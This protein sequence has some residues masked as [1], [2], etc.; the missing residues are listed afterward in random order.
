[1]KNRLFGSLSFLL[2]AASASL[3]AT[4]PRAQCEHL[5]LTDYDAP[6]YQGGNNRPDY[7]EALDM[8][9]DRL[10]IGIP[11]QNVQGKVELYE[12][13]GLNWR[14]TGVV[15]PPP[16]VFSGS[17]GSDVALSGDRLLVADRFDQAAYVY[18]YT[19]G[20]W[21]Y[22]QELPSAFAITQFTNYARSVA[23]DGDRA[24]V[25]DPRLAGQNGLVFVFECDGDGVWGETG[26]LGN[27]DPT[28]FAVDFGVGLALDGDLA[29]VA[30]PR[31]SV[32]ASQ[33]G[34]VY[35]YRSIGVGW[36]APVRLDPASVATVG[37]YGSSVAVSGGRVLVG[38]ELSGALVTLGGAVHVWEDQAGWSEVDVFT[39]ADTFGGSHFGRSV[40][41]AGDL[42]LVGMPSRDAGGGAI[43]AGGAYVF[44]ESGGGWSQVGGA[45]VPADRGLGD[46]IGT[47]VATNGELVALAAPGDD[48]E[49]PDFGAVSTWSLSGSVCP[50]LQSFPKRLFLA[51]GGVFTMLLRPGVAFANR[52]YILVGD[53]TGPNPGFFHQGFFVPLNQDDWFNIVLENP[54]VGLF[55]GTQGT[56]DGAGRATA[57]FTLPPGLPPALAGIRFHW[58]YVLFDGGG[59][60]LHASTPVQ[61][62]LDV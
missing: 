55:S 1:M 25:S 10:A 5:K 58:A 39:A 50:T 36:E 42:A 43:G 61:L 49:G 41:L 3:L 22:A 23:L 56:L 30:A 11:G 16:G 18:E 13:D 19:G 40:A 24:L 2:A 60:A 46:Q 33:G 45:L 34:A 57:T 47:R 17:F 15:T 8:D 53:F 59:T 4:S 35:V 54:N 6:P 37:R 20:A 38:D 31:S 48:D 14:R 29:V 12:L 44:Q 28:G 9:G 52:P 62:R 32:L 27:P 7:G 26:R 21:T 51:Q